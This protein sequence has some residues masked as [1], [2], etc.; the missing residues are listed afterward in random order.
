MLSDQETL[1]LENDL[2]WITEQKRILGELETIRRKKTELAA[3]RQKKP[4]TRASGASHRQPGKPLYQTR[5]T[6]PNGALLVCDD[7][8]TGRRQ[9]RAATPE[10]LT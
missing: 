5:A 1:E 9:L 7:V 6:A 3:A 4:P 10:E 2:A 8:P